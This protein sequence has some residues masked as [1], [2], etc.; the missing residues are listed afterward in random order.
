MPGSRTPSYL[1]KLQIPTSEMSPAFNLFLSGQYGTLTPVRPRLLNRDQASPSV[2]MTP[3]SVGWDWCELDGNMGVR[4][5][6][7]N[8]NNLWW[9]LCQWLWDCTRI[10]RV[11]C[12]L[13]SAQGRVFVVGF[14]SH[15]ENI[16][17]GHFEG[18]PTYLLHCESA[19]FTI[20][21]VQKALGAVKYV[22][23]EA[24]VSWHHCKARAVLPA[25]AN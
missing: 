12:G 22:L 21:Y 20:L 9:D 4:K 25:C 7:F 10:R 2:T 3:R 15:A 16:N 5:S 11:D 6:N 23:K 14:R 24:F 1:W 17:R 13:G 19:W 18:L 8:I